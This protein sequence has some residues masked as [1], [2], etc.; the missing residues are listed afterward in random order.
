MVDGTLRKNFVVMKNTYSASWENVPS[1]TSHAV[2]GFMAG[3]DMF[4][5]YLS[6]QGAFNLTLVYDGAPGP[7][8]PV[9][10]SSFSYEVSKRGTNGIDLVNISVEIEEV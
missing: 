1:L 2:D 7:A 4:G 10:F 8:F 3:A 5:F 6:N 9:M